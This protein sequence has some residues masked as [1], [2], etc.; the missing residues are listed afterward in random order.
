MINYEDE[1][2]DVAVKVNV[3]KLCGLWIF[4]CFRVFFGIFLRDLDAWLV[5]S[6]L[7]NQSIQSIC[8]S[9]SLLHSPSKMGFI[10][11]V[12]VSGLAPSVHL[13]IASNLPAASQSLA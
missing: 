9:D 5:R 10:D 4:A 2:V 11:F 12:T 6:Q 1:C 3:A 8:N 7:E 13:R